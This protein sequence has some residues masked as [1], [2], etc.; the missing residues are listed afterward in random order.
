MYKTDTLA[1]IDILINNAEE[2]AQ[3]LGIKSVLKT[4]NQGLYKNFEKIKPI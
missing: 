3:F 1:G 2:F 4:S